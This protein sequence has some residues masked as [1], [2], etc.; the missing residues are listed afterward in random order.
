MTVPAWD[1]LSKKLRTMFQD[2]GRRDEVIRALDQLRMKI[3]GER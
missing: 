1:V 3:D 2:K